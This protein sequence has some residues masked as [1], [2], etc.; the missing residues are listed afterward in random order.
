MT[1]CQLMAMFSIHVVVINKVCRSMHLLIAGSH[2]RLVISI[3][4]VPV[5][6]EHINVTKNW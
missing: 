3:L 5:L 2:V 4:L 1:S 6:V